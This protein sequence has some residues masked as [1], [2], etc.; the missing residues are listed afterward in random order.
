[1]SGKGHGEWRAGWPVVAGSAVM[2]GTGSGL[3]QNLSSLFLP[4][5]IAITGASRGEIG[6][7]AAAALVGALCAPLIGWIADRIGVIPVIVASGAIIAGA[8]LWLAE[9]DGPLWKFQFG[10]A[11]LALGAPGYSALIYGRLVAQRFDGSRGFALALATSGLS[12]TTIALPPLAG[13]AIAEWG[14]RGGYYL[15]AAL[16]VG[17]GLPAGL[18]AA[19]LAGKPVE[20][21][22]R[23]PAAQRQAI[24]TG[25]VLRLGLITTLVNVGTVGMITQLALIGVERGLSLTQ[26]GLLLSAYGLSQIVGRLLMGVLIDRFPVNRIAAGFGLLSALGFAALLVAPPWLW[27]VAAA[28]FVAG[29]LN[30]ADYDFT[31]FLVTRLFPLPAYGLVFGV[32]TV[33]SIV[34][35]G[36][37]LASFG[38][39]HDANGSYAWPL[40]MGAVAMILAA[41]LLLGL[42]PVRPHRAEA[43]SPQ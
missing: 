38:L 23:E 9:M 35:G 16:A 32:I 20:P 30:G 28:V 4:G 14:W 6:T 12:V 15:L 39:L 33:F 40:A 27:F 18:L 10:L 34:S 17:V 2:A 13:W 22:P 37:G 1:M 5:V 24:R 7:A 26:S 36:I 25:L 11:L 42:P 43:P 41:M 8:L 21:P 31:P 29:L 19:R 3:Y